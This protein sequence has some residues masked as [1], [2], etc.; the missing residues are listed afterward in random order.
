MNKRLTLL[1]L[2]SF[3]GTFI[4]S[5]K[6]FTQP[7]HVRSIPWLSS[8]IQSKKDNAPLLLSSCTRN[9]PINVKR[10][11]QSKIHDRTTQ[12][13]RT[14]FLSSSSMMGPNH[15]AFICDGNSRWAS[16]SSNQ[17]QNQG[18]YEQSTFW[19][20][21]QGGSRCISLIKHLVANRPDVKYVTMYGFS[22]ENW[23][24]SPNEIRDIWRVMEQ[25]ASSFHN[26]AIE[27]GIRVK[28]LG[29]LHD[30]RIPST[31]RSILNKI[32]VDTS[33]LGRKG[34]S[35]EREPLTLCLA[36]NYGGRNDIAN[37]TRKIAE[38]VSRGEMSPEDVNVDTLSGL[39][40]TSGIPDP[41]LVIRTGGEK[42]ISNFLIW[43][44]AYSELYF[45]DVLW[46]DFDEEE[47][48]LAVSW[49]ENRDRRFGG[50]RTNGSVN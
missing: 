27:N 28:I 44:C 10:I 32:E 11:G 14:S 31:L 30:E 12:N 48:D 33:T 15:I 7:S 5:C 26:L 8:S 3:L 36:I 45:T 43:D 39:L 24:R 18:G 40:S 25:T 34:L 1:T 41:D 22:S 37:A 23:S 13:S 19:G 6:G 9:R 47:L 29:E 46:P 21:S 20:H 16:L 35:E 50:R 42:R 2:T 4:Q 49:Y 17:Y 38:L